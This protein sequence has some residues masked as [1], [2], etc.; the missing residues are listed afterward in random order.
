MSILIV[1][2]KFPFTNIKAYNYATINF[3]PNNSHSDMHENS[4][5]IPS[6]HLFLAD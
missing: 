5:A 4:H 1:A 2:E 6:F 3:L